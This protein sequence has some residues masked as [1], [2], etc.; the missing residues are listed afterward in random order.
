MKQHLGGAY[1]E[2]ND[3]NT[4]MPDVWEYLIEKYD[5]R[6]VVDVGTGGGWNGRW[7]HD[8]RIRTLGIEG[9]QEAI[10]R[11]QLPSENLIQHDYTEGALTIPQTDLAWC[12]EFVEH[13]EEKHI[14]NFVTTFKCCKYL[15]LTHGEPGQDGFNHVNCQPSSYWF[16]K[17]SE[18]GLIVDLEETGRLRLTDKWK[19]GWGRRT[20]CWFKNLDFD[21]H[22]SDQMANPVPL[23]QAT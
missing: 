11:N 14:P 20:L 3:S 19:A 7:F 6:S 1:L 18:Y 12:S 21:D 5:I 13:V 10:V 17:M 16:K 4:F 15:C 22:R 2:S 23:L 8:R 9:W